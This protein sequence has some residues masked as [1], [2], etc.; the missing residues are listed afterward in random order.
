V[1]DPLGGSYAVEALTTELER[2]AKE[3]IEKIDSMGGMVRAIE[4][5]FPQKAIEETSYQAQLAIERKEEIIVGVNQF[6]EATTEKAEVLR[7]N[8]EL[9]AQRVAAIR[10]LRQRRDNN[11]VQS[12]LRAIEAAAKGTDNLM[13]LI[14]EAVKAYATVGEISDTLRAVFGEYQPNA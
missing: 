11:K 1:I 14:L 10:S 9:E 7:V 8:P 6:Q 5:G 13:P 2:R 12:A 3:M 4:E